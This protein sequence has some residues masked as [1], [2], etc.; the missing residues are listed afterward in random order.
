MRIC[1]GKLTNHYGC[2][3]C[4][5]KIDYLY[6]NINIPIFERTSKSYT[7]RSIIELLLDKSL[8]QTKISTAQPVGVQE[9]LVFIV[10]V[11]KLNKPEDIRADDL[12]SWICN[13]K[14]S[15][16]CI[17]DDDGDVSEISTCKPLYPNNYSLVKRYYKHATS[18]DFKRVIVEI[19]GKYV[20]FTKHGGRS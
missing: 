10:D 6:D 11:S 16:W 14:R 5:S 17:L 8:P 12:G 3:I 7:S 9:N 15:L 18:G 4:C 20:Y 1:D 2:F 13:G 19:Y